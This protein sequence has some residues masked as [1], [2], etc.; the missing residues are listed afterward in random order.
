MIANAYTYA[1]ICKHIGIANPLKHHHTLHILIK[2]DLHD[3]M[4]HN[5]RLEFR[6]EGLRDL[7]LK[8]KI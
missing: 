1:N 4:M 3:I 7:Q 2:L 8:R 6:D 5:S